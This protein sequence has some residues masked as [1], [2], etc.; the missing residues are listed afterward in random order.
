MLFIHK[1]LLFVTVFISVAVT[2]SI[3]EFT[4]NMKINHLKEEI[5]QQKINNEDLTYQLKQCR[6]LYRKM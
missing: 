5:Y 2:A 3:V 6:I 1:M 4:S